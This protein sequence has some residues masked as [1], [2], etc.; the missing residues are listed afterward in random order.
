MTASPVRRQVLREQAQWIAELAERTI[1]SPHDK[2]RF[3]N[4]LAHV[5]KE[6]D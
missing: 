3:D 5:R 6:L 1:E 4:R 2:T